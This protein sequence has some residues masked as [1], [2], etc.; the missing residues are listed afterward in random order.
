MVRAFPNP[1]NDNFI[2]RF[3]RPV[4]NFNLEMIDIQGR[5][6]K[7]IRL[8]STSSLELDISGQSP[9]MYFLKLS[10]DGFNDSMRL[11]KK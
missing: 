7:Q 2:L 11:I 4:M 9:G 3:N 8:L 5:V 1:V 6:L 10:G